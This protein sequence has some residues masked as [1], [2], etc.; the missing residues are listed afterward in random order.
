[1][2][3]AAP[4]S[5]YINSLARLPSLRLGAERVVAKPHPMRQVDPGQSTRL[6]CRLAKGGD[7]REPEKVLMGL[8]IYDFFAASPTTARFDPL[9]ELAT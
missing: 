7:V 5:G 1:M 9:S 2:V 8:S 4:D 6:F 3:T